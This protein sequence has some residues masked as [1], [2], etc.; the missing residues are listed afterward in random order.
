MVSIL[1]TKNVSDVARP[2][3]EVVLVGD[4]DQPGLFDEPDIPGS[5]FDELM[6]GWE[7]VRDGD[8]DDEPD[9]WPAGLPP[10]LRAEVAARPE[11]PAAVWDGDGDWLPGA[12]RAGFA[13]GGFGDAALPGAG[14]AGLL[15]AATGRTGELAS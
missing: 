6:A 10:G 12:A 4:S 8:P 9:G 13:D 2:A 5:W 3:K 14:L 1:C 11:V 7:L 15:A